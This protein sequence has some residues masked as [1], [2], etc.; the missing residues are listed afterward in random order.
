MTAAPV[1]PADSGT[2]PTPHFCTR[3]PDAAD[4]ERG[5]PDWPICLFPTLPPPPI[6]PAARMLAAAKVAPDPDWPEPDDED[7]IPAL[8][9][10]LM[11]LL[12]V[13][14]GLALALAVLV[15]LLPVLL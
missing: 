9:V 10:T 5:C 2:Q 7:E 15:L 8:A 6:E 14:V 13:A 3:N 11:S 1:P 12:G 4:G